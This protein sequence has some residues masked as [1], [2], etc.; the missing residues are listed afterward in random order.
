MKYPVVMTPTADAEARHAFF[1]IHERSPGNALVWLEEIDEAI[2]SLQHFP[3]RCP[4]AP[5]TEHLGETLRH[6][7]FKSHRIIFFVDESHKTVKVLYIRHAKM[8]AIGEPGWVDE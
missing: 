8:R 6:F 3:S 1:Y 2:K 4:I 5:E 7:I